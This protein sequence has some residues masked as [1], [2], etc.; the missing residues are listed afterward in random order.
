MA[1]AL[2]PE[3]VLEAAERP[4][5]VVLGRSVARGATLVD[6]QRQLGRPDRARILLRYDQAALE[7]QV[8]AA[9]A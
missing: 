7:A 1:M 5:E 8:R 2:R 4:L 6:W 9:L 3:G